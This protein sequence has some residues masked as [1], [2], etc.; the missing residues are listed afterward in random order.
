[1]SPKTPGA[2]ETKSPSPY[3]RIVAG[4]FVGGAAEAP[5]HADIEIGEIGTQGP[6][7]GYAAVGRPDF[8]VD[9][10]HAATA[11]ADHAQTQ[12][13]FFHNCLGR[14]EAVDRV[15]IGFAADHHLVAEQEPRAAQEAQ[16]TKE[17]RGVP[18]LDVIMGGGQTADFAF[19]THDRHEPGKGGGFL[20]QG[21]AGKGGEVCGQGGV[22]MEEA[23]LVGAGVGGAC[24]H[25]RGAIGLAGFEDGQA[26]RLRDGAGLVGRAAIDEDDL[27]RSLGKLGEIGQRGRERLSFIERGDDNGEGHAGGSLAHF[28]MPCIA[29]SC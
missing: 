22:G 13:G 7:F 18:C 26:C 5:H 11:R 25:L 8:A 15:E 12:I 14:I 20:R 28:E 9:L 19:A 3:I 29:H 4:E 24:I 2:D 23:E 1:M 16:W 6:P 17:K 21:F 27:R 10:A